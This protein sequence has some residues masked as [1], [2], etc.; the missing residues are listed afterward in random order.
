M[1]V[2]QSWLSTRCCNFFDFWIFRKFPIFQG[3]KQELQYYVYMCAH[4][5]LVYVYVFV[6]LQVLS[7]F[8][9]I[10]SKNSKIKKITTTRR[11]PGLPHMHIYT[12]STTP[13]SPPCRPLWLDWIFCLPSFSHNSLNTQF[14]GSGVAKFDLS[15]R[16]KNDDVKSP[17][18]RSLS[19]NTYCQGGTICMLMCVYMCMHSSPCCPLEASKFHFFKKSIFHRIDI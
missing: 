9:R 13:R 2:W 1:H 7:L 19:R 15:P 4:I 5:V 18:Q 10:F 11:Q 3:G 14:Q 8:F 6:D 17:K 16:V 12:Y